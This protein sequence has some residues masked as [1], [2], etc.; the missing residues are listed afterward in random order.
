M[1]VI[2]SKIEPISPRLEGAFSPEEVFNMASSKPTE[3]RAQNYLSYKGVSL[4]ECQG[5]RFGRYYDSPAI[6]VPIKDLNGKITSIQYIFEGSEGKFEKRFHKDADKAGGFFALDPIE[7]DETIFVVE[8]FATGVSLKSIL[9]QSDE[10]ENF[11]V[12]CAL[13]AQDVPNVAR[14]L[15]ERFGY[16]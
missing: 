1:S 15:R 6:L 12:V 9:A 5:I 8:G 4:E 14:I 10:V 7:G 16:S 2:A 11:K 13:T 3:I